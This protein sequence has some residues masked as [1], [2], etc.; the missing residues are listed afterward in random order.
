MTKG[1][2]SESF[3]QVLDE[4]KLMEEIWFLAGDDA[5]HRSLMHLLQGLSRNDVIEWYFKEFPEMRRFVDRHIEAG[6][7][8]AAVTE[9]RIRQEEVRQRRQEQRGA[10][11]PTPTKAGPDW[12]KPFRMK[13]REI[14]T[15]TAITPPAVTNPKP[16]VR[17][18]DLLDF[19]KRVADGTMTEAQLKSRAESHFSSYAIPE[20]SRWRPAYGNLPAH[21]KRQAG[22]TNRTLDARQRTTQ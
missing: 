22:E 7:C 18:D 9:L 17:E 3:D 19:L 14:T 4:R 20:K 1:N 5:Y 6:T 10:T 13:P 15:H 12:L 11:K 8:A 16:A 21:L 2:V